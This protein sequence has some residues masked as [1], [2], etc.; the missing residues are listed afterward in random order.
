METTSIT[1][2]NNS[3]QWFSLF[4]YLLLCA[5]DLIILLQMKCI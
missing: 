2:Y 3:F 1:H 4:F 5:F